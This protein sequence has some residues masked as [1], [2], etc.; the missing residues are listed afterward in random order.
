MFHAG[1]IAYNVL[2]RFCTVRLYRESDEFTVD[3]FQ[4]VSL[5]YIQCPP[6][7]CCLIADLSFAQQVFTFRKATSFWSH[8]RVILKMS[9]LQ[10]LILEYLPTSK[11]NRE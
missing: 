9:Q 6:K 11:S 8:L 10:T 5:L 1:T 7:M 2:N 3:T 4:W